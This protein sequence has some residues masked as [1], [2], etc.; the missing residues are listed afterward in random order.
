MTKRIAILPDV[1]LPFSDIKALRAFIRFVGDTQPDILLGIGDYMDYPGPARWSKGT[2]AEY[3]PEL[4]K[5]NEI[6]KKFL[7]EI[8]DV[9]DGPFLM[10][11][12]NHDLRPRQYLA[13]Y[14]PAL[15]E[16]EDAF[17]FQNML[18]FDGFGI[19]LLPDFYDIAPG[20]ISTHGHMG[21]FSLSQIAGSTALN[22]AKKTGDKSVV[23]GHTHRNCVTHH[24][25]GYGGRTKVLTGFEVG[26]F[27][28]QKQATY[29]S[30]GTGNWQLGFGI[31]TVD[32]KHV[33][34]QGILIQN[35]KFIVDGRVWEV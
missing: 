22:A 12:G 34:A 33:Q 26:H 8:R 35:R 11:E 14:A 18:D 1:Q 23:M 28:D 24:T 13:R 16:M 29:L 4:K 32:G 31:L 7:Q 2:A 5:H 25:S 6:G 20:W 15:G 17:H 9:Y 27:M 3:L 19:E 10:H 30:N 21:K